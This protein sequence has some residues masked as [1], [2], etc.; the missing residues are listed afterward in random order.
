MYQGF[1][2]P[3]LAEECVCDFLDMIRLYNTKVNFILN[4]FSAK[5]ILST[6]A[7][8]FTT[9]NSIIMTD[10]AADDQ[11]LQCDQQDISFLPSM[12]LLDLSCD[13][14]VLVRDSVPNAVQLISRQFPK[15]RF[16]LNRR[17]TAF[18]KSLANRDLFYR[19]LFSMLV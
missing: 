19:D 6:R 1:P 11:L 8:I 14:R 17:D 18:A 2:I 13:P 9:V 7:A 3:R 12:K 4:T 5:H 16:K 15:A 10:R